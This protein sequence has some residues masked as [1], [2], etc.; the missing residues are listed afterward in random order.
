MEKEVGMR[1]DAR[2]RTGTRKHRG[3]RLGGQK[4]Q[5]N[6]KNRWARRKIQDLGDAHAKAQLHTNTR[7]KRIRQQ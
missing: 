2:L 7:C 6:L 5:G 1:T 3:D 4:E